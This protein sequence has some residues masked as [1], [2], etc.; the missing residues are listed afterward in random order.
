MAASTGS[1]A[2]RKLTKLTPLT[3]RPSFTSR[4]GMTRT[5]STRPSLRPGVADEPQRLRGI[6]PSIVE[7]T[8]RNGAGQLFRPRFEQ[9]ADVVHRGKAA[10]R[11]DRNGN[12]IG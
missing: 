9:L 2:S 12:R 10:R 8:A 7:C 4:Q 5:L 1:P 6:E 3:T 11:D